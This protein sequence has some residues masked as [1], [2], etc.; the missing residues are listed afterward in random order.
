M[1]LHINELPF[2]EQTCPRQESPSILCLIE[3]L[4]LK[5][6]VISH[7]ESVELILCYR[8]ATGTLAGQK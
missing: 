5:V 4:L 7:L 6:N 1:E 3:A 8:D 2:L